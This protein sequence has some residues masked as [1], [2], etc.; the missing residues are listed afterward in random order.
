MI[1]VLVFFGLMGL[2]AFGS[3]GWLMSMV[4]V[5]ERNIGVRSLTPFTDEEGRAEAQWE[6]RQ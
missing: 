2:V 5:W 6:E 4:E 3:F 1:D